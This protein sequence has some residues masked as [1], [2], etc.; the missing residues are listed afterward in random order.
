[1][2]RYSCLWT[3]YLFPLWEVWVQH[4]RR[5][6]F[7]TVKAVQRVQLPGMKLPGSSVYGF[8]YCIDFR[9]PHY[10]FQVWTSANLNGNKIFHSLCGFWNVIGPKSPNSDIE[11]SHFHTV[12]TLNKTDT[13]FTMLAYGRSHF[14]PFLLFFRL[15][16][17]EFVCILLPLH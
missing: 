11:L 7:I 3:K 15:S 6:L 9:W 8:A 14:G 5:G 16:I 2:D 10:Y 12:V 13:T 4:W 1:M 17:W